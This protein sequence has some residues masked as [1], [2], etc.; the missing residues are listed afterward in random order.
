MYS[1][2]RLGVYI[3]RFAPYH[4]GHDFIMNTMLME[5]KEHLVI[6]GSD[7]QSRNLYTPFTADERMGM[8]PTEVNSVAIRD[9]P[10][11][12]DSKKWIKEIRDCVNIY[13]N[14]LGGTYDVYLY[15]AERDYLTTAYMGFFP[16]FEVR[17]VSARDGIPELSAT[18][19]REMLFGK[20]YLDTPLTD[21]GQ[22]LLMKAFLAGNSLEFIGKFVGTPAF[23]DLQTGYEKWLNNSYDYGDGPHIATDVL[24]R[25]K[26]DILLINRGSAPG[27]GNLAMP[28]GFLERGLPLLAN[29][30][31]ELKEE[32]AIEIKEGT[33][34]T[35]GVFDG[36]H[37]AGNSRIV[38]HTYMFDTSKQP[39]QAPVPGDDAGGAD[40]YS[41][42]QVKNW[43]E[44]FHDDHY[45]IIEVMTDGFKC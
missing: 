3:G 19:I 45:H 18:I 27:K 12:F 38:S 8:L 5:C 28:G 26:K 2:P 33:P 23:D 43:Q 41:L 22:M 32:T 31:K 7:Q 4:M 30:S 15:G 10:Y 34:M 40:W 24:V 20:T 29:A 6:V 13:R 36:V 16:E 25:H 37:R 9:Y 11:P 1:N 35:S 39:K 14:S 17:S 21:A 42:A 44:K